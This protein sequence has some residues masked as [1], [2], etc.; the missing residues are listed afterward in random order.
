MMKKKFS[1]LYLFIIFLCALLTACKE[2]DPLKKSEQFIEEL[3]KRPAKPIELIPE[4]KPVPQAKYHLANE[5]DPYQRIENQIPGGQA[6]PDLKRA[7]EPLEFYTLDSLK[8]VGSIIKD[9]QYFAI[10]STPDQMVYSVTLGQYMGQNFGK[11]VA[12]NENEIKLVE[13]IQING[14]WQTRPAS[15][16]LTTEESEK[17][18]SKGNNLKK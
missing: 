12:L 5:R 2:D 8:M 17:Q 9:G 6:M 1:Y 10:V 18:V 13:T 4:I 14:A 3:K 16:T 11:I 15:L 7:K